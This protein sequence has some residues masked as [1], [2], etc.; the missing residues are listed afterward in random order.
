MSVF[1]LA[2]TALGLVWL[3]A[4]AFLPAR[5]RLWLALALASLAGLG[6]TTAHTLA[7]PPWLW[8]SLLA[9]VPVWLALA[10]VCSGPLAWLG[11]SVAWL[12]GSAPFQA[13]LLVLGGLGLAGSQLWR[14]DQGLGADLSSTEARLLRD[15]ADDLSAAPARIACTDSGR[16]VPLFTCRS[17]PL[18]AEPDFERRYLRDS[19]LDMKLIQLSPGDP[20]YNCHGWVFAGGRYWLR[21]AFVDHILSDNGYRTTPRARPGDVAVFRNDRGEVT[22][23]A[24]VRSASGDGLVLVESKFGR[25]G[26]YIHTVDEHLY[27]GQAVTYYRTDRGSHYLQGL[28]A[29]TASAI[30]G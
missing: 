6:A 19:R 26:R 28:G 17:A 5:R 10:L 23:S 16:P 12:A 2:L 3:L 15:V 11:R 30:G 14:L 9:L 21:G 7:G 4:G 22:H 29:D 8:Q 13:L 20:G 27:R 25:L 24:L 18:D 1:G